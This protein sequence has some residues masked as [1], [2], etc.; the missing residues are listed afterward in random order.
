MA[1]LSKLNLLNPV[2]F[3]RGDI[4]FTPIACDEDIE[5]ALSLALAPGQENYVM[6]ADFSLAQAYVDRENNVPFLIRRGGEAVGFL[7]LRFPVWQEDPDVYCWRV[8]IDASHQGEGLGRA[9]CALAME[10]FK[11]LGAKRV[12]LAV[13]E[14][15]EASMR[16]YASL[17]FRYTGEHDGDELLYRYEYGQDGI[18]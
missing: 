10:I 4:R 11:K 8:L 5:D 1:L 17:G 16:L 15:N 13:E 2:A 14:T 6:P 18:G 12:D 7:M 3:A 9:A